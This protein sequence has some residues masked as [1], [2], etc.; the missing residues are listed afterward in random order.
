MCTKL[1]MPFKLSPRLPSFVY[2]GLC[3][4]SVTICVVGRQRIFITEPA[5]ELVRTQ[6]QITAAENGFEAIAYCFMPDHLH[7]LPEGTHDGA[8]FREFMRLFKQRSSFHWKQQ[9]GYELWQRSY[10]ERVL[11]DDEDAFTVARYILDN[12]V[13]AGLAQS[14]EDSGLMETGRLLDS[15]RRT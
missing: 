2:C 11:R 15:I 7:L 13:R 1:R 6:L 4:Y 12:P 3:R 9:H 8:D 14:P 10:I 5:V